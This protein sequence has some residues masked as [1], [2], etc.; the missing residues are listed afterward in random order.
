MLPEDLPKEGTCNLNVTLGCTALI[1]LS[2]SAGLGLFLFD[3]KL[4]KSMKRMSHVMVH[5]RARRNAVI[6]ATFFLMALATALSVVCS[7]L[8]FNSNSALHYGLFYEPPRRR[9]FETRP[10]NVAYFLLFCCV[11]EDAFSKRA[12]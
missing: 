6:F 12:F 5:N 1:T 4:P 7:N 11:R 3:E 9:L 2:L 8:E 10:L